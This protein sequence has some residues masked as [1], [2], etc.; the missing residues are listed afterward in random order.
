MAVPGHDE[1]DFEFAQ[2]YGIAIKR[3]LVENEDDDPSDAL[4][5]AFTGNGYMV[6]SIK[7]GFDGKF[8]DE[9]KDAVASALEA[10]GKGDRQI[11]S[12]IH[13]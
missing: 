8:G 13:I 1:R 9:A 3:V 10:I 12:L 6:N 4:E 7:P 11:L 5:Q 2:K